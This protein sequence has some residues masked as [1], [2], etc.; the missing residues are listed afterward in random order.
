MARGG[1]FD[2]AHLFVAALLGGI[3]ASAL[4]AVAAQVGDPL[5]LGETNLIDQRT[6]WRGDTRGAVLQV[7]NTGTSSAI[8]ARATRAAIQLHVAA[9][10]PP[11]TVNSGAGTATNLSADLLDGLD[12]SAFAPAE[13]EARV[14]AVEDAVMGDMWAKVD[15]DTGS[16][17]LLHW[18]KAV[19]AAWISTGV[20]AVTFESSVIGCGWLATRNDNLDGVSTAGEISVELGGALDP[21]TLWIRTYDSSGAPADPSSTD[22]FTVQVDC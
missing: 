22:G 14:A 15:A 5:R 16:A 20:F 12:S 2:V 8:S 6:A 7:T 17:H 11:L 21:K 4:P 10:K 13:V 3:V 1:R 19:S 9:G 18:S